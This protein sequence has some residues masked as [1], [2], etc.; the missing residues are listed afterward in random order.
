[1]RRPR[2]AARCRGTRAACYAAVLGCVSLFP[3]VPAAW[4]HPAR[5]PA[6]PLLPP[7][8]IERVPAED[9]DQYRSRV[10]AVKP[11]I[12]GLEAEI[13]G[14]QEKLRVTWTGTKT[15]TVLGYA[16]EPMVRMSARGIEINERSPSAYLSSDRYAEVPVPATATAD[17]EPRWRPIESAGPIAWYDHRVQWMK[18]ERPEA[19][20]DGARSVTIFHWR[21]PARL[22][23]KPIAISGALDWRPDPAAIR[24]RRSE[25][26]N[27]LLSAL[28]LSGVFVVGWLVGVV[29]RRRGRLLGRSV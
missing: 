19:V 27:P 26:S 14:N 6:P 11:P 20:G 23:A 9:L 17:A 10:V 4:A 28:I 2:Q 29:L 12:P 5:S 16:G 13:V 3:C 18:A 15:L 1:M 24:A 25:V 21:V 8:D 7:E 22:G